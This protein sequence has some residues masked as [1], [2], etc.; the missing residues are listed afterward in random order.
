[1]K[2]W[3]VLAAAFGLFAGAQA[4]KNGTYS[5]VVYTTYTTY[6]PEATTFTY[7]ASVRTVRVLLL[8]LLTAID[9]YCF[10]E[11]VCYDPLQL[12]DIP[13]E[14][15]LSSNYHFK[16]DHLIHLCFKCDECNLYY[17]HTLGDHNVLPGAYCYY[18]LQRHLQP[19]LQR[20]DFWHCY[21]SHHNC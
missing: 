2:T 13:N 3:Q 15:V 12:R 9:L 19:D 20:S 5:T 6:C 8:A 7:Q 1:M 16:L 14:L 21:D 4:G 17:L 18:L 11:R 10:Q